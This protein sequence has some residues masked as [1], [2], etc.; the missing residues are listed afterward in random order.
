MQ[1]L[2]KVS[3]QLLVL[4]FPSSPLS[5]RAISNFT[6]KRLDY[7]LH[8]KKRTPFIDGS[9]CISCMTPFLWN[10]CFII[11]ISTGIGLTKI[12]QTT[13]Q[14]EDVVIGSIQNILEVGMFVDFMLS[15]QNCCLQSN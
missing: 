2:Q 13:V 10:L 12:L 11:M 6:T 5:Q 15:D 1:L 3:L 7:Q 8:D 9:C 14:E 4:I